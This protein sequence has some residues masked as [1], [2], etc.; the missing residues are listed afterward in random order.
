MSSAQLKLGNVCR[1]LNPEA[2][3]PHADGVFR[4]RRG[5]DHRVKPCQQPGTLTV[6]AA[7]GGMAA[8]AAMSVAPV[9]IKTLIVV[10]PN[11]A[12]ATGG[13]RGRETDGSGRER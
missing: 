6:A 12:D 7:A 4:R 1:S 13:E 8:A 3:V 9:L 10:P 5:G 11:K 2:N